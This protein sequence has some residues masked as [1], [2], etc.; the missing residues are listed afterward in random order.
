MMKKDKKRENIKKITFG[1]MILALILGLQLAHLPQQLTGIGVNAI[2]IASIFLVGANISGAVGLLTP[3]GGFLVGVVPPVLAPILPLLI[4]GNF[5]LIKS[6]DLMKNAP[7]YVRFTVP[8]LLKA[9]L[10]FLPG[11]GL[12]KILDN[13][14]LAGIFFVF[15]SVQLMTAFFGVIIG[16]KVGSII[17]KKIIGKEGI[18]KT[19]D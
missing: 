9:G 10:I 12:I 16:E 6:Y 13:K 17:D 4:G 15:C 1:G 18:F 14:P 5:I 8:A 3:A 2:L 11:W 19:L 7:F